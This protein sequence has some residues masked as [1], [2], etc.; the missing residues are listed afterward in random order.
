MKKLLYSAAALTFLILPACTAEEGTDPGTD[1]TPAV[2]LYSYTP[3]DD[4][5][6]PDNDIIIRFSTNQATKEVAY[7]VEKEADVEAF[8][9]GVN[10][11][12]DKENEAEQ[13][14]IDRVLQNGQKLTVNGADNVDV[15]ITDLY[16]PYVI[17]AVAVGSRDRKTASFSGLDWRT[18]TTGT[19]QYQQTFAPVAARNCNLQVCTTNKNLYRVE[20]AFGEKYSLKFE[21]ISATAKDENKQEYQMFR[22]PAQKT[23]W[24]MNFSSGGPY[25]VRVQDVGYWQGNAAFVNQVTQYNC[26]NG[27]YKDNSAFFVL[28]WQAK[29]PDGYK[30]FAVGC[31]YWKGKPCKFI[32][33]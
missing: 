7:L 16:G 20:N 8:L 23:G 9:A 29:F 14:Y 17:S 30:W 1:A 21:L 3:N 28:V 13:A 10:P 24:S 26:Q 12:G 2:T 11:N 33:D 25:P 22:V 18:V 6:N 4:N 32:P 19:F 15:A 31:D 27:M 5:L